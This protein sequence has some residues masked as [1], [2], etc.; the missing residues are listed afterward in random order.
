MI[1]KTRIF[2]L[3]NNSYKN[4]SQLAQAMGI[5]VSQIYRV[6]EGKR[7][8]NQKF[9]VGAIKAFPDYRLGEL[10][11]LAPEAEEVA[12]APDS[13]RVWEGLGQA[14]RRYTGPLTRSATT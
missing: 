5:S 3:S 12:A 9:I 13:K 14:E 1:V 10:F 8:I 7:G 2:E 4:M 6:R 11:Y